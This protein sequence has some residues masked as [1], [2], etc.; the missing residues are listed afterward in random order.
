M[1]Q[2]FSRANAQNLEVITLGGGCFW[3]T[4]AVFRVVQGVEKVEAGY[5]GG[6]TGHPTYQQVSTG[7]TGHAEVVQVTF[8]SDIISVKKILKI[9]FAMHD[10][11][12]VN[13]QGADMGTQYRSVIFFHNHKQKKTAEKLIEELNKAKIWNAPVV[14]ELHPL[15]MFYKAEKHHQNYYAHNK[16]QLYCQIIIEPKLQKL[17][18][19]FK[20]NLKTP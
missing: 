17:C 1:N 15:K 19:R 14:T 10:P 20:D 18:K 2:R 13:R 11:T 9:F 8:D 12:T 3:C 5:A 4:E 16:K 6:T 7:K